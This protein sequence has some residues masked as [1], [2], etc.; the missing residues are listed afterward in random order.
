MKIS[1][2]KFFD[3]ARRRRVWTGGQLFNKKLLTIHKGGR[4]KLTLTNWA[5]MSRHRLQTSVMVK[6][7]DRGSTKVNRRARTSSST[8]VLKAVIAF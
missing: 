2:S 6:T 5:Q 3:Y 7:K 8:A 1:L 4:N